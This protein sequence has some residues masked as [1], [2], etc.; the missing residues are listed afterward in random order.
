MDYCTLNQW[1]VHNTY[2]LPLIG[3]ILGHLQGKTLFTKMDIWWGYN[4]IHI[5][6]EDRWKAAFK[7][8]FDLYEPMVMYFG[9]TH[10]PATF[11]CTMKKKLWPIHNKYPGKVHKYIDDLLVATEGDE[12]L[13]QQIVNKIL[14]LFAWES[15]FLCPA[16]CKFEQTRIEYLGLIVDREQLTIDPKNADGL[17]NWPRE[18]TTVKEVRSVL[19]VLGYQ[20]PFILCKK[21]SQVKLKKMAFSHEKSRKSHK[22]NRLFLDFSWLKA[23]FFDFTWLSVLQSFIPHYTNIAHPLMALTKK[24]QLFKWTEECQKALDTLISAIT[25]G[26]VLFC[27]C[28]DMVDVMCVS[29]CSLCV[30]VWVNGPMG[31]QRGLVSQTRQMV[32]GLDSQEG[33]GYK[34]KVLTTATTRYL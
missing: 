15:Y 20:C 4:N 8:P 26:P 31:S 13:H 14:D 34:D 33:N 24:A 19:G 25:S 7:T 32:R 16:K 6:E 27:P 18:L 28:G 12:E 17:H 11:S 10:S 9:L 3:N 1:T 22:N 2:P 30:Q 21:E 29:Q 5:K 23:V